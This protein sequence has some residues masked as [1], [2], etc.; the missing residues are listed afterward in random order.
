V[1]FFLTGPSSE[2]E[3]EPYVDTILIDRG[4]LQ[5]HHDAV[6]N[7]EPDD[8]NLTGRKLKVQNMSHHQS[9]FQETQT[10]PRRSNS[11]AQGP[12]IINISDSKIQ[13]S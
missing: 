11:L 3:D 12:S 2:P 10:N 1:E 6:D 5:S 7:N 8:L 9:F 4:N 13:C